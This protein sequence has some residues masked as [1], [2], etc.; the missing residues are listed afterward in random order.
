VSTIAGRLAVV[1]KPAPDVTR[2][3]RGVRRYLDM[4]VKGLI[5][6]VACPPARGGARST[7]LQHVANRP[8]VCHVLE[9]MASAGIE[10]VV[11][12]TSPAQRVEL[13]ACVQAEGPA[14]IAVEYVDCA[15]SGNGH[16]LGAAAELIG[17]AACVVHAADGI[18][19]QPLAPL[20]GL[21]RAGG[22]DLVALAHRRRA[23]ADHS[24][25]LAA[26]RLLRLAGAPYE[27]A[28]LDLA[29]VCLLG[30]GALREAFAAHE[31]SCYRD[32][33]QLVDLVALAQRLV[34]G[35]GR[36][37]VERVGGWHSNTGEAVELL[38]CNRVALEALARNQSEQ[39]EEPPA[40]QAPESRIEGWVEAH[41]TACVQSSVIVGP[42]T[43]GPGAQVLDAYIGPYTAIGEGVRIEGAEVERSIIL[44]GARISHIGGRLVGSVVGRNARIVRDFSLPRALRV[45]V[46]DGGEVSLC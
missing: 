44:Q 29:G 3:G 40:L 17:A 39:A 24:V 12:L 43:L 32:G 33:G 11:A 7:A 21:L 2:A 6:P 26:R 10:E 19:T 15:A 45:N 27:G 28:E 18:L 13:R 38:E 30:P 25:G 1:R 23:G 5:A 37:D 31:P 22:P 41:P 42:A 34:A 14:E 46:G 8:L 16:A 9:A 36:L 20:V 4:V 35:G